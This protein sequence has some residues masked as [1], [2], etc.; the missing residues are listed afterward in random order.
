MF[1]CGHFSALAE[2]F[3]LFSCGKVFLNT[4][5]FPIFVV[6][7]VLRFPL[8]LQNLRVK[9]YTDGDWVSEDDLAKGISTKY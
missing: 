5:F 9:N 6:F 2:R 7:V 1:L 4:Q 8:C 3:S